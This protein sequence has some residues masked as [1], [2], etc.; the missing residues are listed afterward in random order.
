MFEMSDAFA[1]IIMFESGPDP[2]RLIIISCPELLDGLARAS[3]WLADGTIKVVPTLFFQL[4]SIHF[5]FGNGVCPAAVY[6]LMT[7]KSTE[8]YYLCSMS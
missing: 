2:N 1:D 3:L 8:N 4:Y 7:N 5:D 6:C